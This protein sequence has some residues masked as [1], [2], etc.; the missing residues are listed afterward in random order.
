MCPGRVLLKQSPQGNEEKDPAGQGILSLAL[1]FPYSQSV[2]TYC[3]MEIMEGMGLQMKQPKNHTAP[4]TWTQRQG[5]SG[6]RVFQETASVTTS[7]QPHLYGP[8]EAVVWA[9]MAGIE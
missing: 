4:L 6:L 8:A 3:L 1:D 7:S 5:Y 2:F 9:A